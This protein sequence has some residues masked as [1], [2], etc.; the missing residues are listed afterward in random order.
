MKKS[1][2]L[3][4]RRFIIHFLFII[5]FLSDPASIHECQLANDCNDHANREKK[6]EQLLKLKRINDTKW[7]PGKWIWWIYGKII[8]NNSSA[9]RANFK[10]NDLNSRMMEKRWFFLGDGFLGCIEMRCRIQKFE[11][12]GFGCWISVCRVHRVCR[13]IKW[14]E[15]RLT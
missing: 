14:N 10:W 9:Q 3:V 4:F 2:A 5:F 13:K 11:F 8:A 1:F 7:V 15:K 6:G 12:F